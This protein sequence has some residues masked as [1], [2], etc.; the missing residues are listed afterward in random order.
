MNCAHPHS[1]AS[2][3]LTSTRCSWQRSSRPWAFS[4]PESYSEGKKALGELLL[5]P[6]QDAA[7]VALEP[8][9]VIGAQFLGDETR[10]LPLAVQ[11]VGGEEAACERAARQLVEQELDGGEF[12]ALGLDRL[13]GQRQ[14]QAVADGREQLQ[15]L[16]IAAPAA[17]Q[18]LAIDGQAREH[19]D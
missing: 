19:G 10:R 9:E 13:L 5:R 16:A 8:E 12:L 7:L 6:L 14:P 1:P 11:G 15:R 4:Q 18:G 3:G 2:S 17:A